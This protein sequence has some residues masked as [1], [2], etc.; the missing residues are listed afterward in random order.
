[1]SDELEGRL[2]R[3]R[4]AGPPDDLRQHVFDPVGPVRREWLDW[5]PAV[6]AA[7]AIGLFSLLSAELRSSVESRVFVHVQQ[8]SSR[9]N[10]LTTLL[11]GDMP[12]QIEAQRLIERDDEQTRNVAIDRLL[13]TPV[14]ETQ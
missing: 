8:Q 14:I 13:V 10:Q 2:R 3:Y 9:L 11:G 7:A 5:L 6:A 1:V 4:P 12:A